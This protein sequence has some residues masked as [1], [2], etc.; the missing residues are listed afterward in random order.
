MTDTKK[1]YNIIVS[2]EY[3]TGNGE[4]KTKYTTVGVAF[5]NKI[6]GFNCEPIPGISLTGRFFIAPRRERAPD[7]G[8]SHDETSDEIPL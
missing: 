6:G 8:A 5:A 7:D 1:P 2:E 4:V 3:T